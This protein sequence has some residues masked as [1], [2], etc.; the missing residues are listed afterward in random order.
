MH[1]RVERGVGRRRGEVGRAA[2]ARAVR[3]RAFSRALWPQTHMPLGVFHSAS[4][5]SGVNFGGGKSTNSCSSPALISP[6]FLLSLSFRRARPP[7]NSRR[8]T[9]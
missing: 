4:R 7:E 3:G 5:S 2:G 9:P 8:T 6:L 1:L